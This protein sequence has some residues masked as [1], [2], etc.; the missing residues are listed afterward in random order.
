[1]ENKHD[2]TI[3]AMQFRITP[4]QTVFN[5][6][7]GLGEVGTI[8]LAVSPQI[9]LEF[10]EKKGI[11]YHETQQLVSKLKVSGQ[12]LTLEIRSM[13]QKSAFDTKLSQK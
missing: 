11:G 4:R 7:S 13:A 2:N 9:E 10:R 5:N 12:S 1:M 6:P 3:K 8:T